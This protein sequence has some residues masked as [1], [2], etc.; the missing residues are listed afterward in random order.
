MLRGALQPGSWLRQDELAERL[1]VS[2]IPVREALQ[3]LAAIGLL[4]FEPNRGVTVPRLSVDDAEEHFELRRAVEPRLLARAIPRLTIAD[5]A[6]AEMALHVD[7]TGHTE[8]NWRFHR[9][10]YAAS[11]WARGLDIVATL[12]IAV[13]PYVLLYTEGL[14]GADVS[15]AQHLAILQA[16]RTGDV[17]AAL[18][19]LQTHLDDAERSLRSYLARHE[20]ATGTSG[21][22]T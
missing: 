6:A 1:D 12:N 22:S 17:D 8:A 14:G 18:A 2:K 9:A 20:A 3:R 13:A 7:G 15:D 11:G 16:C 5:L 21:H 10:L 19:L 4:R